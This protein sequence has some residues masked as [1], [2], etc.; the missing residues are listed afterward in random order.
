MVAVKNALNA[1]GLVCMHGDRIAGQKGE[2]HDFL[3][4]KVTFPIGPFAVAALTGAPIIPVVVVKSGLFKYTFE[5]FEPMQCA[6]G[7]R[8]DRQKLIFSAMERYV[9]IL[10]SIVGKHPL[11][12][13]NFYDYFSEKEVP[14]PEDGA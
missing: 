9:G 12:W 4:R 11:Q 2:R 8:E 13:F 5:A 7:S 1:N 10:E 6:T 14:S 3:G